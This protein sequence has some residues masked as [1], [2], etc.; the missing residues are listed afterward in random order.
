MFCPKCGKQVP[1]GASF[2]VGCGNPMGA[3]PRAASPT[4]HA[5]GT[6]Y[7]AAKRKLPVVPI[8]AAVV[9][10]VVVVAVA[11]LVFG[12]KGEPV[13]R[14]QAGSDS[15][16]GI[17]VDEQGKTV[18]LKGYVPVAAPVNGVVPALCPGSSAD[19]E[20]PQ[21]AFVDMQGNVK[22]LLSDL[23]AQCGIVDLYPEQTVQLWNETPA[24]IV[25]V[26]G[27]DSQDETVVVFYNADGE[28]LYGVND[29]QGSVQA[30]MNVPGYQDGGS[31]MSAD[32]S[33]VMGGVPIDPQ[34]TVLT[35]ALRAA[36]GEGLP[37]EACLDGIVLAADEY[38]PN[39]LAAFKSDGTKVSDFRDIS[40]QDGGRYELVAVSPYDH[41]VLMQNDTLT[42]V[43]N[44]ETGKWVYEP[45]EDTS[46]SLTRGGFVAVEYDRESS[47]AASLLYNAWGKQLRKVENTALA[48]SGTGRWVLANPGFGYGDYT[49]LFSTDADGTVTRYK[50]NFYVG[51]DLQELA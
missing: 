35:D 12:G 6:G 27:Y 19:D 18:D 9:A 26:A 47:S 51:G 17:L 8:V 34:G 2:C 50:C 15:Y 20:K 1:E 43:Y 40:N 24:G 39:M 30:A 33:L 29:L 7:A 13:Y 4:P 25:A 10:V 5:A 45:V 11:L 28:L 23:A 38:E 22:F 3:A 48:T 44:Y 46:F 37:V 31:S 14:Y 42:G 16:A 32:G 41:L 36:A 21:I 49:F